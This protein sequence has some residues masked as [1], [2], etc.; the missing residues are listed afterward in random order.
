MSYL[1]LLIAC[2]QALDILF[3][4]WTVII[5]AL[6]VRCRSV[7]QLRSS[8]RSVQAL[9]RRASLTIER[10]S[11]AAHELSE[12]NV[13]VFVRGS[14]PRCSTHVNPVTHFPRREA[15]QPTAAT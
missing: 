7:E 4:S 8:V 11:Q 9:E 14:A 10:N 1:V 12:L 3:F 5:P 6:R 13:L 2:L 15:E